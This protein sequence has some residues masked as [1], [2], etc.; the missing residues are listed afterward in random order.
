MEE[1]RNKVAESALKV[2]DLED[3]FPSKKIVLLDVSHW[4][5]QGFILKESD[6]R[7]SL[8]DHDWNKYQNTIVALHCSTEA[9]LPAWTFLLV[10]SHLNQVGA[11]VFLGNEKEAIVAHY[12]KTIPHLDFKDYKQAPVILKG[13]SKKPVPEEA[14]LLALEYLQ[15]IAKSIMFGEACS[16]VPLYKEKKQ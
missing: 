3:Y 12:F 6:F 10:A 5:F 9:I 14:Y 4:L 2:F 8:K 7:T 11:E 1:I 16:A 13:C 15:P